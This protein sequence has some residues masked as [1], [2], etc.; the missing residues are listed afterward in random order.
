M[1]TG[2]Y[3][4]KPRSPYPKHLRKVYYAMI[5]RCRD[6]SNSVY[7]GKGVMVC[8]EWLN[9]RN[10]FYQWAMSNGWK[11]GLQIDKDTKGNG[12]LYSPESCCFLTPKENSNAR[13]N[14][15]LFYYEGKNRTIPQISE[16]CGI[17][18]STLY[19]RY[20]DSGKITLSNDKLFR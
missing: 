3:K 8:K 5:E 2:Q 19:H 6:L 1:P 7:G 4:R 16:M 13:N 14:N 17:K 12:R 11:K 10:L 9:D 18:Q 15:V 20:Y